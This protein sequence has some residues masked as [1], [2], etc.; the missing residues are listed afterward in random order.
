ML[1]TVGRNEQTCHD[2]LAAD[3][4]GFIPPVPP[5]KVRLERNVSS[6]CYVKYDSD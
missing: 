1:W 4:S 6:T 5:L 3:V 2:A